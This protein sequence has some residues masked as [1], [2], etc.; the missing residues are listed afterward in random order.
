[1]FAV[2]VVR[3][4]VSVSASASAQICVCERAV[5]ACCVLHISEWDVQ[6]FGPTF[7]RSS[8][9]THTTHTVHGRRP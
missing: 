4:S 8:A 1:V 5:R 7:L 3:V 2:Q 9:D 6:F